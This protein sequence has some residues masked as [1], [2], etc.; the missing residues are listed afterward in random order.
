[1]AAL[2]SSC[3]NSA[4]VSDAT[5]NS[6]HSDIMNSQL[7]ENGL[8]HFESSERRKLETNART[9][10]R[11]YQCKKLKMSAVREFPAGCGRFAQKFSP[12][13]SQIDVDMDANAE[14]ITV[15][16]G[17][18]SSST[19]DHVQQETTLEKCG[20]FNESSK[21]VVVMEHLAP[22]KILQP[23]HA[24]ELAGAMIDLYPPETPKYV[25]HLDPIPSV[26]LPESVNLND[27]MQE[28]SSLHISARRAF[29][30]GCGRNARRLTEVGKH[31]RLNSLAHKDGDIGKSFAR[32]MY[33]CR[34]WN[35]ADKSGMK[36]ES[37]DIPIRPDSE[38]ISSHSEEKTLNGVTDREI[39]D[40][41]EKRLTKESAASAK[42]EVDCSKLSMK[43]VGMNSNKDQHHQRN[44]I[45]LELCKG[46]VVV[47]AL[48][49]AQNCPWMQNYVGDE[50]EGH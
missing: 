12:R 11:V 4:L 15:K 19:S 42:K 3:G 43:P 16:V 38:N 32:D 17:K 25:A 26:S 14:K 23:Q 22:S 21:D 37:N 27:L 9:E 7:V 20:Q 49:A 24:G 39:T 35:E 41:S 31:K 5:A 44:P 10:N 6:S 46:K 8:V 29:P 33:S 45:D 40:T 47:L 34:K 48:M 18:D 36:K 13:T 2:M 30:Y 50:S 1:M 28:K